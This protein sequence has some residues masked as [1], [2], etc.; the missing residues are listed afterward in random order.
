MRNPPPYCK[1]CTQRHA[2]AV[3]CAPAKRVLDGLI[4]RGMSFDTPVLEFPDPL[5]PEQLGLGEDVVLVQ[6]LMVYGATIPT[7]GDVIRP[8]LVFTGR[9]GY[10]NVLPRWLYIGDD[11]IMGRIV[12]LVTVMAG[13]AVQAAH[14][15]KTV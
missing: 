3:M 14:E 6:Q 12:G 11:E 13:M 9:D 4:E 7:F 5:P 2:D 8:A 1:F 15:G 10:G